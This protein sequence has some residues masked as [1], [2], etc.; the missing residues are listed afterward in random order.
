MLNEEVT[1]TKLLVQHNLPIATA[2]HLDP[3]FKSIFPDSK[4]VKSYACAKQKTCAMINKAFHPYCHS[5]LAK[6][7][8]R[9][10]YSVG[11]DGSNDK[12]IKKMKPACVCI[13]D[14]QCSNKVTNHCFNM[15]Y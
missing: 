14:I 5:Y 2:D 3:L 4:I 13:F 10:P 8:K 15:S 7:C 11:H 12:S 9:Y 1:A 6:H